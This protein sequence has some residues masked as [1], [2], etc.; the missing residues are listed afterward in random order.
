MLLAPT[1][2]PS[3]ALKEKYGED[4]NSVTE[5]EVWGRGS[6]G[7]HWD[8]AQGDGRAERGGPG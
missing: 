1:L 2:A 5:A 6:R 4:L 8:E 3:Q 7:L